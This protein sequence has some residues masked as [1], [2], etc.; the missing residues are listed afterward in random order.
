MAPE[1][2]S[3]HTDWRD[4]KFDM[5]PLWPR[6]MV[7]AAA[8]ET[9]PIEQYD[10]V[11][12]FVRAPGN[13]LIVDLVE[14]HALAQ[15]AAD[16]NVTH[17]LADDDTTIDS[18]KEV[19]QALIK[20]YGPRVLP[21]YGADG[22]LGAETTSATK[23]FQQDWNRAHPTDKLTVDGIPGVQTCARLQKVIAGDAA[24]KAS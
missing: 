17:D 16:P 24:F 21:R 6:Q 4:S 19:Q 22:H 8:F 3:E 20:V 13:N 15:Q 7:T 23:H 11:K 14:L 5:G 9:Y 18:T 2:M 1:R 12:Q 10:F